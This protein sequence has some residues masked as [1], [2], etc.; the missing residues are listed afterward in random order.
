MLLC[1]LWC[2]S[3][4]CLLPQNPD[5]LSCS[6]TPY[7]GSQCLVEL[8][9]WQDCLPE[10]RNVSAEILIPSDVNQELGESRA[11]QLFAGLQLVGPSEDCQREFRSF[12]CLLL[13]GGLCDG[14]GQMRL[15]SYELCN[16]LQ[17]DTCSD[18]IQLAATVPEYAVIILNCNNFRLG[19]PPCGK[20]EFFSEKLL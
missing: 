2:R 3:C 20:V 1:S 10:R 4:A 5:P 14:S 12:W 18:L 16:T 6:P 13:F 8:Q 17:T 9:E 7:T 11:E 19:V 15:P